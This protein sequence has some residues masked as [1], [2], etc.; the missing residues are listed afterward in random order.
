MQLGELIMEF[1]ILDK[2]FQINKILLL[3]IVL[4]IVA[5]VFFVGITISKNN[6][7]IIVTKSNQ[8]SV[9]KETKSISSNIETIQIYLVGCVKKP[10]VYSM[11]KGQILNDLIN[12]A[13][14]FTSE[15]D[16]QNVN[17]VYQLKENVMIKIKSKA[18][19]VELFTNK[20]KNESSVSIISNSG[21]GA[22]IQ[23]G[24]LESRSNLININTADAAK[25]EELP[26][27]GKSTSQK[28]V[29]YRESHGGFKKKEDIMKV[30]GIGESKFYNIKDLIT[31]E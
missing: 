24:T 27:I 5:L 25:L 20:E 26:G 21:E 18:E 15:A 19:N 7:E 31:V 10:G 1:E 9:D 4:A 3:G 14:G 16:D 30:S 2:K 17:L 8:L 11:K 13:G 6:K 12:L 22:Q 23:N 29:T 28:I